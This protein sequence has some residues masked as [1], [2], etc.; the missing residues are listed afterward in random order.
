VP[1]SCSTDQAIFSTE[2]KD[3]ELVAAAGGGEVSN[4]WSFGPGE[5]QHERQYDKYFQKKGVVY[6]AS[7]GD[8]NPV[9]YPSVSPNVVSSGGT[10]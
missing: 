3:A 9:R 2:K 6:F 4:S 8:S 7:S 10:S 5:I 1:R